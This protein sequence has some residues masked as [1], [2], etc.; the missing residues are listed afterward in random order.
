MNKLD[1]NYFKKFYTGFLPI[2]F[3]L[4]I[5]S[6]AV[7]EQFAKG[8]NVEKISNETTDGAFTEQIAK[9]KEFIRSN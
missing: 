9:R 5:F 7:S 6:F 4:Q 2:A 8:R 1:L 3:C